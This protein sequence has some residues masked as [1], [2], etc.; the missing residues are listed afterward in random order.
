MDSMYFATVEWYDEFEEGMTTDYCF[1]NAQDYEEVMKKLTK[2]YGNDLE[3]VTI[4]YLADIPF[5]IVRS[6]DL[7]NMIVKETRDV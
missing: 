1:I 5:T 4:E 7:A 2:T 3:K 6:A